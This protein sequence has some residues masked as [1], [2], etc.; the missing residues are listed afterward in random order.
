MGSRIPGVPG[1]LGVCT[2]AYKW[3]TLVFGDLLTHFSM[4]AFLL[5]EFW[6]SFKCS[7]LFP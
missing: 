1:A 4:L 2:V 7:F 6:C 5:L 3:P